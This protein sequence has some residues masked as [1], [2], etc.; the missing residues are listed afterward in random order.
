MGG[1]DPLSGHVIL[2]GK[3]VDPITDDL[4][5]KYSRG[6]GLGA[7]DMLLTPT[8]LWI[9]SDNAQNSDACGKTATGALAHGHAGLCFLPY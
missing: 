8:G 5:G 6:R 7:D 2:D 4:V 9:A 1:V 3:G